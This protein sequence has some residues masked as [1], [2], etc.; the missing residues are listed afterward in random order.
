MAEKL[1]SG[2]ILLVIAASL[3]TG[4]N[5]NPDATSPGGN[6]LDNYTLKADSIA[7]L[8]VNE[9]HV[10]LYREGLLR[11]FNDPEPFYMG[12]TEKV[13]LSNAGLWLG[14]TQNNA[15]YANLNIGGYSNYSTK[16]DND[17]RGVYHITGE[18]LKKN[19]SNWPAQFGAPVDQNGNPVLYGDEMLISCL[20]GTKEASKMVLGSP[21][22]DLRIVQTI[23]GYKR[24]DISNVLFIR[25][26]MKNTGT[27]DLNG[28]YAGFYT[29]A[30]VTGGMDEIGYDAEKGLTFT[31]LNPLGPTRT[32]PTNCISG[33]IFLE[34]PFNDSRFPYSVTGHRFIERDYGPTGSQFGEMSLNEPSQVLNVLKAL[35]NDGSGMIDPATKSY[36]SFAFTGNPVTREGWLD[37]SADTRNMICT[38]PFSLRASE[39]KTITVAIITVGER[40][41]GASLAKLR[42]QVD[43]IRNERSLWSFPVSKQ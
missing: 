2:F 5:K 38:G 25:Y 16:W 15:S 39:I 42:S 29:D 22:E 19:I 8:S 43:L 6:Q 18:I 36:T 3:I 7:T 41:L 20:K 17:N 11:N 27:K 9:I 4:C 1:K 31:Y 28:I 32:N 40:E 23:Y 24:T 21:I 35:G 33:N 30:D 37:K 10:N 13:Y 34:S 14:T 26:E 12:P